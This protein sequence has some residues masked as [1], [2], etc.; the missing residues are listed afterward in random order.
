MLEAP[1]FSIGTINIGDRQKGRIE[2]DSVINCY[3]ERDSIE[4]A[5]KRLYSKEFQKELPFVKNPYGEPGA[6][7][8]I[9]HLLEAISDENLLKKSFYNLKKI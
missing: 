2:A 8:H 1:T 5:F 4:K 7:E 9:I 3:P 6:S